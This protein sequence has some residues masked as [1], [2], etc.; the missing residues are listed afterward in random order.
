MRKGVAKASISQLSAR[1]ALCHHLE[2]LLVKMSEQDT[3][4][5]KKGR[6]IL[7]QGFKGALIWLNLRVVQ[8]LRLHNLT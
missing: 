6:P 4:E 5:V 8:P 2:L 1:M 3:K 7:L